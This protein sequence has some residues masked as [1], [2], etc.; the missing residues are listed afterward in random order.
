MKNVKKC[1][2]FILILAALLFA[3]GFSSL[4]EGYREPE[5]I[6]EDYEQILPK[7]VF[8]PSEDE[9]ISSLG[10]D[11]LLSEVIASLEGRIGQVGAFFLTLVGL[12]VLIALA[13]QVGGENATLVRSA[14]SGICALVAFSRIYPLINEI[15]S[16]LSV[17]SGFFSALIP[18]LTALE[19]S[20]GGVL[21][22]GTGA[23]G[24]SITL[25]L[26]ALFTEKVLGLLVFSSFLSGVVSSFG[27]GIII[28]SLRTKTS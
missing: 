13:G 15:S 14:V 25:N 2:Q 22:A 11:A 27:G 23:V 24:M 16:S 28:S 7:G 21:T 18:I 12:A 10:I 17:I 26:A 3:F 4:A 5:E 19:A 9:L 6:I 8:A 20:G 1:L